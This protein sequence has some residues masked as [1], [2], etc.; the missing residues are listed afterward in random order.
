MKNHI[1]IT[2]DVINSRA[3]D[4]DNWMPRLEASLKRY[5]IR[6]DIYRGDSF[7]AEMK[8][9]DVFQAIFHLKASL[10]MFEP[11]DVRVG[12]GFGDISYEDPD[13][14]KSSGSAF[15]YSGESFDQLGRETLSF[16]SDYPELDA[17][18][19]LILSLAST[20]TDQWKVGAA[21]MVQVALENPNATQKELLEISGRK[22]Q[23]QV[24]LHLSKAHYNKILQVIQYCTKE[25]KKYA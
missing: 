2:G 16:K 24:S 3:Q 9:E 10:R 14:K 1:I 7:Q 11:N 18:L 23:S 19:N 17:Q 13:I 4:I 15:V 12:I 21:E 20:I 6:H 5:S 22:H 25:L 8:L